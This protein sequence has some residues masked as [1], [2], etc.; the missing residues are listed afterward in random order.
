[1]G[2]RVVVGRTRT[3]R[4][5][6]VDVGRARV[7]DDLAVR[8]VLHHDHEDVIERGHARG[9]DRDRDVSHRESAG[10]AYKRTK[11]GCAESAKQFAAIL[12]IVN[13]RAGGSTVN[14]G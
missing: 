6:T 12:V 1:M 11:G 5:E 7:A 10:D 2:D 3:G 13:R 8:V 9:L 14:S 4:G